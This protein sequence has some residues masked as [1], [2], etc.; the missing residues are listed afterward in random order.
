[1]AAVPSPL[2]RVVAEILAGEG[3][4]ERAG[5]PVVV[6]ESMKMHHDVVAPEGGVVRELGVGVGDQ[7][8]AVA[9]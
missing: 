9:R 5:A 8:L 1:M 4:G 6:L 7:V 3:A 2:A